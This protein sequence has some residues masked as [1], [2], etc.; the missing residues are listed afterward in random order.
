MTARRLGDA[1]TPVVSSVLAAI[2]ALALGG[3]FLWLRG[4]DPWTVYRLMYERGPG[5]D[6]GLSE[7]AIRMAPLLIIGAGLLVSLRAGV[8]NIGIDGQFLLGAFMTGVITPALLDS[9]GRPV[10]LVAG[11]LAGIAGGVL[12]ALGPALLKI[13]FGLNEIITTLMLNYLAINVTAWL[14]KGP[15]RD[16]SVVAPQTRVIPVADRLPDIPGT[17][18]HIGL[19]IG[20]FAVLVVAVFFRRTLPG[21]RLDVL[22]RNLRAAR[23]AGF[24][25]KRLTAAALLTSGAMAGLAGANDVLGVQGVFK[26]NWNPGYGFAAFAIVYLARLKPLALIPAAAFLAMLTIGGE[27]ASRPADTPVYFVSLLE[28]LLLLSLAAAAALERRR[29]RAVTSVSPAEVTP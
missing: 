22:G 6:Y 26:G 20:V 17:D 13:W 18:V 27:L 12:W 8:W 11:I 9:V 2:V 4:K 25:V 19:L 23:Y 7:S 3:V 1:L 15:A 10:A 5:A 16:E 24:P 29:H 21:F 14:V 28:G